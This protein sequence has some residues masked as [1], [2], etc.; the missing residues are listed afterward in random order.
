MFIPHY[1]PSTTSNVCRAKH[2]LQMKCKN[3]KYTQQH[4]LS[5]SISVSRMKLA[6]ISDHRFTHLLSSLLSELPQAV[7]RMQ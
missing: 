7:L 6:V 4:V 5:S 2:C 1:H 3:T